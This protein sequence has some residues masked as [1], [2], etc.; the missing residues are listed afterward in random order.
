ML[1]NITQ[2]LGFVKLNQLTAKDSSESTAKQHGL[3]APFD[4]NSRQV[5]GQVLVARTVAAA[6]SDNVLLGLVVQ[7]GDAP[8]AARFST[9]PV[10]MR[11][12]I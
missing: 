4:R 10:R 7:L 2:A 12:L 9:E 5:L 1:N 8:K 11:E 3:E 6:G